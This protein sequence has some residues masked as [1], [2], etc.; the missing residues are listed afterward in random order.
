MKIDKY[1]DFLKPRFLNLILTLVVLCLPILRE[2]YN[3]GEYVTYYRPIVV[4]IDYFR[5]F[6]QPHLLLVMAVFIFIDYFVVSLA[7]FGVSEFIFPLLKSRGF[8]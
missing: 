2:Q 6:Q 3:N 5:N 7:I 1:F 4:M 8:K